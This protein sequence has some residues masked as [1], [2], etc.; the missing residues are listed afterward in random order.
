MFVIVDVIDYHDSRNMDDLIDR[1]IVPAL[2]P[3]EP[4]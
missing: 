1:V 2:H 4:E 3:K